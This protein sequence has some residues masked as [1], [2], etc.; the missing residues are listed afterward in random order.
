[1]NG[2][3]NLGNTCYMNAGLQLLLNNKEL[4]KTIY[5]ADSDNIFIKEIKEFIKQY[6]ANTGK[7]LNPMFIKKYIGKLYKEFTGFK[8]NDSAEFITLLLDNMG[9]ILENDLIDNVFNIHIKNTIKCKM[10]NCLHKRTNDETSIK[11]MFDIKNDSTNLDDCYR[12]FKQSEKLN[13]D[14]MVDCTACNRKT[15]VS[16]RSEIINWPDNLIIVLKRFTCNMSGKISKNNCKIN[17]PLQWRKGYKLQGIVF[18]SGGPRGG[19][20][21]YIG[22]NKDKWYIYNDNSVS[23]IK[24]GDQL[25]QYLNNGYIYYF[26]K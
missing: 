3:N 2:L 23:L 25:T 4:C 16:R 14:N 5:Q 11:L 7:V 18:H 22:K 6:H 9:K 13:R 15:I 21:I 1:M 12:V 10:L 26:T 19:H 8:Q 17:V 20:Y 24:S